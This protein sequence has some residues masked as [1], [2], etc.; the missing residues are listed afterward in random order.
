MFHVKHNNRDNILHMHI[1]ARA[2]RRRQAGAP[3]GGQAPRRQAPRQAG[4]GKQAI[5]T[6]PDAPAAP[7][8][9]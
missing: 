2:R 1:G 3:A 9:K 6:P 8:D 7:A 4:A 5:W